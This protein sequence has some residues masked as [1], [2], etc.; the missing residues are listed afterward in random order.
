M[1]KKIIKLYKDDSIPGCEILGFDHE[2]S[3]IVDPTMDE[4]GRFDI[5]NPMKYYGIT[6][7]QL[8]KLDKH[9]QDL[10]GLYFGDKS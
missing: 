4:T 7:Q 5:G 8:Y 2:G 3:F 10:Y 1:K 6:Q 9:N